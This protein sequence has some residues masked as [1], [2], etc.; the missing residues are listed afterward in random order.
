MTT[1][2]RCGRPIWAHVRDPHRNVG[3]MVCAQHLDWGKQQMSRL[4]YQSLSVPARGTTATTRE[5][6]SG[7]EAP[8]VEVREVHWLKH[9]KSVVLDAVAR[10]GRSCMGT[11][12][13]QVRDHV[14][15]QM[16]VA[17]KRLA[18]LLQECPYLLADADAS[19]RMEWYARA[20][21][22]LLVRTAVSN[23]PSG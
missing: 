6:I 10:E 4:G 7:C 1:P 12:A 15:S 20:A 22:W 21:E 2:K 23:C 13:P 16:A 18:A 5:W 11:D 3:W 8:K 17:E 14:E 19:R 9:G